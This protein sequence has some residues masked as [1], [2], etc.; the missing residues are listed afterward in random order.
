MSKKIYDLKYDKTLSTTELQE[1][2]AVLLD[3]LNLTL[4]VDRTHDYTE[5][6]L[7]KEP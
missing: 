2:L 3:H 7:R 4:Y 6:S 5:F 1:I